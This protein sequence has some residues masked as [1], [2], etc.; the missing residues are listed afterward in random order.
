LEKDPS[1]LPKDYINV[2]CDYGEGYGKGFYHKDDGGWWIEGHMFCS[3]ID[4]WCEFPRSNKGD[5]GK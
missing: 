4:T 3:A 2:W 5:K 1:D